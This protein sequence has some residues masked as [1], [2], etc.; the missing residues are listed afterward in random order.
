MLSKKK[1][2]IKKKPKTF[3]FFF[4]PVIV[5]IKFLERPVWLIRS[6][7]HLGGLFQCNHQGYIEM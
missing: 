6:S 7:I 3:I 1:N 5:M 4:S 2:E